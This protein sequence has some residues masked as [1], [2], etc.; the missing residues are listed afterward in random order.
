MGPAGDITW[1]TVDLKVPWNGWGTPGPGSPP[2]DWQNYTHAYVSSF[3]AGWILIDC[4]FRVSCSLCVFFEITDQAIVMIH[5]FRV[6]RQYWVVLQWYNLIDQGNTLVVLRKNKESRG[7]D[8]LM[9]GL[10]I[11]SQAIRTFE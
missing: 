7:H 3:D 5:D 10:T 9:P 2:S 1:S 8:H 6:R 11:P 4:R